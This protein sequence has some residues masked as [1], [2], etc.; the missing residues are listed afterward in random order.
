MACNGVKREGV[1]IKK[2]AVGFTKEHLHAHQQ[3]EVVTAPR[4]LALTNEL[5]RGQEKDTSLLLTKGPL[6]GG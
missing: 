1:C 6:E 4:A 2:I 5:T 3:Q